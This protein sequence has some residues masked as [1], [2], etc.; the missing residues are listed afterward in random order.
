MNFAKRGLMWLKHYIFSNTLHG[1]HSP[2]V[3]SFL[4]NIVYQPNLKGVNKYDQL[5]QRIIASR[6]IGKVIVFDAKMS[7]EEILLTYNIE[8]LKT[9]EQS[10][11]IFKEIRNTDSIFETWKNIT[12]DPKNNIS[13][14]FFECGILF[15]DQKKPKEHFNIYYK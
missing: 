6:E 9:D 15:F 4:E 13:I 11:F 1:T 2:F 8:K 3:Y 7:S 12:L 5:Y 10:I 14:D